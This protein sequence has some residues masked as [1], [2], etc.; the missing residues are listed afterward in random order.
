MCQQR[1]RL[2]FVQL[3]K[4]VYTYLHIFLFALLQLSNIF[5]FV[6]Y[7]WLN[8]KAQLYRKKCTATYLAFK[9]RDAVNMFMFAI[10]KPFHLNLFF[11]ALITLHSNALESL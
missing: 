3:M 11:I 10:N 4:C 9:R 5:T 7:L 2:T 8:L 6:L 1:K